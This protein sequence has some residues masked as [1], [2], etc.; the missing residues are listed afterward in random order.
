[1]ENRERNR[2]IVKYMLFTLAAVAVALIAHMVDLPFSLRAGLPLL[3]GYIAPNSIRIRVPKT[4]NA[5]GFIVKTLDEVGNTPMRQFTNYMDNIIGARTQIFYDAVVLTG[6]TALSLGQKVSLFKEGIEENG[7]IWNT[8]ANFVKS[9]RHTNMVE[10]GQF[11]YGVSAIV[12]AMEVL[13]IG[14]GSQPTTIGADGE[15]QDS[16][17]AAVQPVRYNVINFMRA[18]LLQANY[19]FRRGSDVTEENGFLIDLPSNAGLS[20]SMGGQTNLALAQNSLGPSSAR[21]LEFP[22]VLHSK[23]NFQVDLEALGTSLA[24]PF[25]TTFHFRLIAKRLRTAGSN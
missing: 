11:E 8:A 9:R 17:D 1:M 21:L 24:I 2:T 22:K 6:G 3:A 19:T 10:S 5:K 4:T 15:I 23:E 16:A 20:G 14:L 7:K 25:T 12:Y 13:F 18:L